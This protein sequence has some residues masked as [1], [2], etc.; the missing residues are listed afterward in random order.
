MKVF[1][2]RKN[3]RQQK[4]KGNILTL[5]KILCYNETYEIGCRPGNEVLKL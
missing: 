1:K 4:I 2:L 3:V 5:Q